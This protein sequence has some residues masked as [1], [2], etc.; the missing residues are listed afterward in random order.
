MNKSAY[1]PLCC[2]FGVPCLFDAKSCYLE[3]LTEGGKSSHKKKTKKEG[4]S[5]YKSTEKLKFEIFKKI[6]IYWWKYKKE[7][8]VTGN[9]YLTGRYLTD[10]LVFLLTRIVHTEKKFSHKF[11]QF[12]GSDI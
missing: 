8:I 7:L 5:S 12:A 11:S 6:T 10:A 9:G 1:K 4:K 3:N 2:T